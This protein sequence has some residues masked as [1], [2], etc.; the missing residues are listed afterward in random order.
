MK[1]KNLD[2]DSGGM[3]NNASGAHWQGTQKNESRGMLKKKE[4][5]GVTIHGRR[6]WKKNTGKWERIKGINFMPT[7]GQKHLIR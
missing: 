6:K 1:E 5:G 7:K 2:R 4:V 3:R